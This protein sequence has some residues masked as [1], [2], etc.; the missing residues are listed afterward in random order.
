MCCRSDVH[1]PDWTPAAAS[2]T[3]Q[4]SR[5]RRQREIIFR[6]LDTQTSSAPSQ[7]SDVLL[8]SWTCGASECRSGCVPLKQRDF[9]PSGPLMFHREMMV[10]I[11]IKPEQDEE[12][13]QLMSELVLSARLCLVMD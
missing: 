6:R 12:I 10:S 7:T 9:Y 1:T 11:T 5:L 8:V 2:Q 13:L 4:S 3:H